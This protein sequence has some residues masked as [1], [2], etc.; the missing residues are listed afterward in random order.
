VQY[1][2]T[3]RLAKAERKTERKTDLK[4]INMDIESSPSTLAQRIRKLLVGFTKNPML[5]VLQGLP[6][7]VP[8]P[9]FID[10]LDTMTMI[11]ILIVT[12]EG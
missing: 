9:A 10:G 5:R 3:E 8:F 4:M 6:V 2:S 12:C 7:V 1:T 11:L